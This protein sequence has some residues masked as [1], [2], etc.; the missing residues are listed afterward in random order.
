V[1]SIQ[2]LSDSIKASA[3]FKAT[4]EGQLNWGIEF[5]MPIFALLLLI[6]VA[7]MGIF[8]VVKKKINLKLL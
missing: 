8:L 6:A 3:S 1:Y 2:Q 7:G 5:G 4:K